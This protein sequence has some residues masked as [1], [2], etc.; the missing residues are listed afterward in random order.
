VSKGTATSEKAVADAIIGR[1]KHVKTVGPQWYVYQSGVWRE[2]RRDTYRPLVYAVTD[3]GEWK[4]KME[5][6]A[7]SQVEGRM[8]CDGRIFR[9]ATMLQDDGSVALNTRNGIL[10]V[11]GDSVRRMDHNH[12]FYFTRAFNVD[13]DAN[14]TC[15]RYEAT[16]RK[17]L[18]DADDQKLKQCSYGNFLWP[19]ARYEVVQ[20]DIGEAGTG[21][22]TL[23]EPITAL[24]GSSDEGLLTSL[25]L[26]QICDPNCYALAKL[27]YALVNLGTELQSLAIDESE[28]FKKIVSGEPFEARPIYCPPFTMTTFP[29]LW[30]LANSIPRF[31]N[32]TDAELRRARFTIFDQKPDPMDLGLKAFLREN[33]RAGI[34]NFMIQGLQML[35]REGKMPMG[36]K[37]SQRLHQRFRVSNDTIRSFVEDCCL[38]GVDQ[39][40]PK[41]HVGLVYT[42]YCESVGLPFKGDNHFFQKLYDRYPEITECRRRFGHDREQFVVGLG[43]KEGV[44]AEARAAAD[45]ELLKV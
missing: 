28:N 26:G 43:L 12:E 19:D 31:K 37:S 42:D 7:L 18:P 36:G 4:V 9:G 21:K 6:A 38:V 34:F 27:R 15:P 8:Q 10:V 45:A 5:H 14:A 33:E 25:S 23:A 11:T 3:E 20:I 44:Y 17:T 13:Y 24:L 1:L 39:S 29:K 40:V 16:F 30:F 41:A 2:T 22:S 32:G 35:M